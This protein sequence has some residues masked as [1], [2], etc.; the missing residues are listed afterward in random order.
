MN[1][2]GVVVVGTALGEGV[3]RLRGEWPD[4]RNSVIYR[5]E[6]SLSPLCV[7]SKRAGAMF[8]CSDCD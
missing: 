3:R 8:C 5:A 7:R 2:Y 1:L 6:G 4:S